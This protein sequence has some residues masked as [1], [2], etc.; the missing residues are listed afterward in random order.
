MDRYHGLCGA[1]VLLAALGM[2]SACSRYATFCEDEMNCRGGNDMD[3]DACILDMNEAEDIADLYGC[4]DDWDTYFECLQ[5]EAQ[6]DDD[7]WTDD[8]DCAKEGER[9]NKCISD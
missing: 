4:T 7:N 9:Y 5:A 8:G 6:C 2:L 1:I 3:I